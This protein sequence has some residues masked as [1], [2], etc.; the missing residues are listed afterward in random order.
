[1]RQRTLVQFLGIVFIT[2]LVSLV[3][4]ILIVGDVRQEIFRLIATTI[5][6]PDNLFGSLPIPEPWLRPMLIVI[7]LIVIYL[8]VRF[9]ILTLIPK[10]RDAP[11]CPK[12]HGHLQR[13]HRSKS[14]RFLSIVMVS[15]I[16]RYGCVACEWTGLR[17]HH[18]KRNP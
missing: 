3:G 11:V 4:T 13:I 1:M 2:L 12:C 5:T 10:L 14:E 16:L 9:I 15:R 6:S 7:G 8:I 17:R 18:R